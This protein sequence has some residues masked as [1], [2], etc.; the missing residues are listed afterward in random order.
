MCKYHLGLADPFNNKTVQAVDETDTH[1]LHK[2]AHTTGG[3][4]KAT[5][6]SNSWGSTKNDNENEHKQNSINASKKTT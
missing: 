3:G 4:E 1:F 2:T 6:K 5:N